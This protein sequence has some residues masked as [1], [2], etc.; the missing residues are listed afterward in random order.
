M[1]RLALKSFAA[2][3]ACLCLAACVTR[4]EFAIA[5]ETRGIV[6]D[7]ARGRPVEGAEVR[8]AGVE[9]I[10]KVTTGPDGRFALPGRTEKRTIVALPMGGLFRDSSLVQATAPGRGEAFASAAFIQGGAPASALYGVT[11]LMFP[12]D[13]GETPLHALTNDC[14]SGEVQMHALQLL[15]FASGIDLNHPPSW[16]DRE[17][18]AAL[19]EH[20]QLALPS[21]GFA[22]CARMSEAYALYRVQA[23]PLETLSR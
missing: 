3:M 18:A 5:P 10:A 4:R 23:K 1:P 17:T 20:L 9:A 19:D 15:D 8:F 13:A 12:A 6:L 7:A 22:D 21:S 16:L 11:V 2:L 14:L